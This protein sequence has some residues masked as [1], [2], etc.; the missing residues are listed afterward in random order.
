MIEI[1]QPG[2][3]LECLQPPHD[4]PRCERS[5]RKR[6]TRMARQQRPR[7]P[8]GRRH[9]RRD[10]A[11]PELAMDRPAER[12]DRLQHAFMRRQHL[13]RPGQHGAS[14]RRQPDIAAITLDQ[15]LA[16]FLLKRGKRGG[17]GRLRDAAS[18]C[19][20]REMLFAGQG[21]K[22]S[23]CPQLHHSG[24]RLIGAIYQYRAARPFPRPYRNQR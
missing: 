17:Q 3:Q 2:V 5:D 8:S 13:L 21:Q 18:I 16:E 23:Q 19:S 1:G 15:P 12:L 24:N 11:Q 7:Q 14:F 4:L 20:P 10:R 9:R 6:D 22:V